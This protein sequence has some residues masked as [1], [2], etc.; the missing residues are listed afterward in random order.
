MGGEE[1][2]Q[3][4]THSRKLFYLDKDFFFFFFLSSFC[5]FLLSEKDMEQL[6]KAEILQNSLAIVKLN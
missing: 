5:F 2:L 4:T 3:G 1:T 6:P